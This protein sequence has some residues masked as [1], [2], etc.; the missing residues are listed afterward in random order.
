[1][2]LTILISIVFVSLVYFTCEGQRSDKVG[3]QTF[4]SLL[5]QKKGVLL[6]V[7]MPE[8][9]TAGHLPG[10]ML[11]DYYNDT[12][13]KSAAQLDKT[14]PVFVYCKT[15]GRSSSA[16]KILRDLGFREVY[17]LNG[18]ITAWKNAG[19]PVEK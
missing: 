7:R 2:K 19:K 14:K 6:D 8:E 3:V 5:K 9:F 13:E 1:M 16:A 4:E 17:D 10:A 11:L 12:F 15:G 18:G